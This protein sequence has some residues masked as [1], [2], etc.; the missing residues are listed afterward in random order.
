MGREGS[1]VRALQKV[2]R[3]A[4]LLERNARMAEDKAADRKA[5]VKHMFLQIEQEKADMTAWEK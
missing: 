4:G 3:D 1:L 5:R 2:Q